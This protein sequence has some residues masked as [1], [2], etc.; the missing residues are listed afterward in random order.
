MSHWLDEVKSLLAF[1]SSPDIPRHS[2]TVMTRL[3]LSLSAQVEPES[4]QNHVN[5][6]CHLVDGRMTMSVSSVGY[7]MLVLVRHYTVQVG[8]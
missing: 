4:T 7:L 6:R 3:T 1:L 5:R 2:E 8:G